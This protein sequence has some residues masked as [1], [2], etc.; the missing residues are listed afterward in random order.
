MLA[1]RVAAADRDYVAGEAALTV[2]DQAASADDARLL[3]EA[4]GIEGAS[5][6]WDAVRIALVVLERCRNQR[7]FSAETL[8][9]YVPRRARRLLPPAVT[10]LLKDGL[11]EHAGYAG[12]SASGHRP[13]ALFRLTVE[14]ERLSRWLEP[15]PGMIPGLES[16][17]TTGEKADL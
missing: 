6:R 10:W 16:I 2:A 11:I 12:R 15:P 7:L 8:H 13:A 14:G 5:C 9:S 4:L 1:E 3:L 17:N